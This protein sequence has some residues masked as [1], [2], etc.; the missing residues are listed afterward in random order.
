MGKETD[1][2]KLENKAREQSIK[3][4]VKKKSDRM[5]KLRGGQN[6]GRLLGGGES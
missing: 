4:Q 2:K 1:Y 5:K 3:I 6:Q